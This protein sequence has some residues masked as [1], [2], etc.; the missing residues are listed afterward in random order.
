MKTVLALL[1]CLFIS[2][3]ALAMDKAANTAPSA[4]PAQSE[5]YFPDWLGK[6]PYS[7][8][9]EV[10]DTENKYGRYAKQTKRITLNDLIKF[11]SY[12]CGGLVESACPAMPLGLRAG[13][14]A[15][16]KLGELAT[17][18]EEFR[19]VVDKVIQYC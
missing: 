6:S 1:L 4:E 14:A 17:T 2:G 19:D 18:K 8:F 10:R 12:F 16:K 13:L 11:H 7:P 5:W 9:F 15:M 3:E